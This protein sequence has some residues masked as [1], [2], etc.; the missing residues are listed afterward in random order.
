VPDAVRELRSAALVD[1]EVKGRTVRGYAAVYDTPWNEWLIEQTGYVEKVAHGA[2]RKALTRSANVPL[3]WQHDRDAMLATT[4][5]KTLRLKDDARG[6]YF[7]GDLPNTQLGND[8]RELIA[9]GDVRGMSYGIATL[10]SDSRMDPHAIPPT[11]T[12]T[13]AQRLL[14]V[15]LTYEPAYESTTVEMRT[16]GF[17]AIPLQEL[18]SGVEA[19]ADDAAGA[20]PSLGAAGLSQRERELRLSILERGG[21]F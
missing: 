10:P 17:A 7:E 9:R 18:L 11:R 16:Q 8:V 2:F 12:V 13:N 1:A 4:R 3:L 19:Q 15:T 5:S 21:T 6:L 14:D 20:T